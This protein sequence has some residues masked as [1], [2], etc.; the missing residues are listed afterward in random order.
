M[1]FNNIYIRML[2]HLLILSLNIREN[3][4]KLFNFSFYNIISFFAI[5]YII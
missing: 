3:G 2:L 1:L 4:I 5:K